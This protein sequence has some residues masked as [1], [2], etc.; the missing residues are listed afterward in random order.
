M[1]ISRAAAALLP[2]VLSAAALAQPADNNEEAIEEILVLGRTVSLDTTTVDV[3]DEI[4]TDTSRVLR[5]LPGSD[6]NANGPITGIAQHRGMFGDR[7]SV[8]VDG[9]GMVSGGPQ[10]DGLTVILLIANVDRPHRRGAR[11]TPA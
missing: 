6:F 4:V 10:R 1:T 3:S 7:V 8:A 2:V 9:V 11:H 5:I